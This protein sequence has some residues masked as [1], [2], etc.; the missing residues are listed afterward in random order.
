MT[1]RIG[2]KIVCVDDVFTAADGGGDLPKRG[3]VYTVRWIGCRPT[4]GDTPG[5][6]LYE[7]HGGF[8]PFGI[9]YCFAVHRFRPLVERKTDISIFKRMLNPSKV[10]A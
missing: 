3:C 9:E 7:I 1:F 8:T 4:D 2:Q 10:E 6:M 5:V